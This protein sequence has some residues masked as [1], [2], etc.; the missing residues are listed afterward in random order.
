MKLS[1]ALRIPLVVLA[2]AAA[3]V[4]AA[5]EK[6][7]EHADK[8]L[9]DAKTTLSQAIS[10][11]ETD[12]GGKA[13]SARLARSHNNDYYD[14]RVL[15]GDQLTDVHVSIDEGKILGTY[16]MDHG[17]MAAKP[18]SAMPEKSM[19]KAPQSDSKG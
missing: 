14:V 1:N 8:V 10:A 11:A 3:P 17:H 12:T 15:K 19:E 18:K 9:T 7:L 16:P 2:I 6:M 5:S 13:L 4:F